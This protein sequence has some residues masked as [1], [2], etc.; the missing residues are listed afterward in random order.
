MWQHKPEG[1][2]PGLPAL[3]GG[4]LAGGAI[5]VVLNGLVIQ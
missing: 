1:K 2:S 5:G 4:A 3:N